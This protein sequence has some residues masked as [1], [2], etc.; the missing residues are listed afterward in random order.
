MFEDELNYLQT[1]FELMVPEDYLLKCNFYKKGIKIN[2]DRQI[3]KDKLI[4]TIIHDSE[5]KNIYNI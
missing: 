3:T 1:Y 2:R 5:I 4:S